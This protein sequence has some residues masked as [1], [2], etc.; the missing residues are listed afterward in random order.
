MS[1][2]RLAVI[3]AI[4]SANHHHSNHSHNNWTF[5]PNNDTNLSHLDQQQNNKNYN[6]G[7]RVMRP[8]GTQFN[9]NVNILL[10]G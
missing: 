5:H 2:K 10:G 8:N 6:Q 7:L 1:L 9:G 3:S 4:G